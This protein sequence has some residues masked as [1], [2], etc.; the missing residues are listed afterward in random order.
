MSLEQIA[1]NALLQ[2]FLAAPN[3][4]QKMEQVGPNLISSMFTKLMYR[5]AECCGIQH[6]QPFRFAVPG[7]QHP[8]FAQPY[9]QT[10]PILKSNIGSP[11][12]TSFGNVGSFKLPL[13]DVLL[14]TPYEKSDIEGA[15]TD[16]PT[17][18]RL[19]PSPYEESTE[20]KIISLFTQWLMSGIEDIDVV[21][22]PNGRY[23]L[24]KNPNEEQEMSN[25]LPP[26]SSGESSTSF[27][28]PSQPIPGP[29]NIRIWNA[30]TLII[31]LIEYQQSSFTTVKVLATP[32]NINTVKE[33]KRHHNCYFSPDGF[34]IIYILMGDVL[35]F[36]IPTSNMKIITRVR[37]RKMFRN[38]DWY[39]I[40][41]KYYRWN[42]NTR[43]LDLTPVQGVKPSHFQ[44]EWFENI[45]FSGGITR[46]PNMS[47]QFANVGCSRVIQLI[48]TEFVKLQRRIDDLL[49]YEVS[50][51]LNCKWSLVH[52][53]KN[54]DIYIFQIMPNEL[55]YITGLK[56][57][58]EFTRKY[59]VKWINSAQFIIAYDQLI[60][61]ID[62]SK[63]TQPIIILDL[64]FEIGSFTLPKVVDSFIIINI[65]VVIPWGYLIINSKDFQNP[66][67]YIWTR[68]LYIKEI[69]GNNLLFTANVYPTGPLIVRGDGVVLYNTTDLMKYLH[70]PLLF[71]MTKNQLS[72]IDLPFEKGF[73]TYSRELHLMLNT[74]VESIYITDYRSSLLKYLGMLETPWFL[75][76]SM[77][78]QLIEQYHRTLLTK[79]LG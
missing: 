40:D 3:L 57:E 55:K 46:T 69:I 47:Y 60:M 64:P 17:F 10:V 32:I 44:D 73:N 48:I 1:L 75:T 66:R 39:L 49:D 38:L 19:P 18:I 62:Q 42:F 77:F 41:G 51:S 24:Y 30:E 27:T 71:N 14:S 2:S 35:I 52:S 22:S 34:A 45:I 54:P 31:D 29:V 70:Y 43:T 11:F 50:I 6:I 74:D 23:L 68:S 12:F 63:F 72:Y 13:P 36:D 59:Y 58:Y 8:P 16:S 56:L 7:V 61:V 15:P 20:T 65:R 9:Y 26:I 25:F 33:S 78:Q 67:N 53:S 76:D 79:R 5:L 4:R 37:Y 28:I 21:L